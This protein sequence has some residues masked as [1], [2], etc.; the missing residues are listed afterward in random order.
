MTGAFH[1]AIPRMTPTGSRKA[2]DNRA[3]LSEGMTSPL[4]CVVRAAASRIIPA[5]S[6]TLNRAHGSDARSSSLIVA[7]N[8][9]AWAS[10]WSA[11]ALRRD[12][13]AFGPNADQAGKAAAAASA[14]SFARS[15]MLISAPL[16]RCDAEGYTSFDSVQ[17]GPKLK[18]LAIRIFLASGHVTPLYQ[19][20]ITR[21]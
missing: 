3:G 6:W 2:R 1:G 17:F 16:Q 5:P 13:R 15:T 12:L 7:T 20:Q 18:G 8:S 9:S 21:A 4:I 11:A 14:A 19:P 10:I